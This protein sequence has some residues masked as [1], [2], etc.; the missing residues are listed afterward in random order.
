MHF[1]IYR[2]PEDGLYYWRLRA[3]NNETVADGAEGYV[4]KRNVM[5]AVSKL[6][7]Q[8]LNLEDIPIIERLK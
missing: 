2:S 1:Q 7:N 5:R 3:A 4:S 8:M 6:A